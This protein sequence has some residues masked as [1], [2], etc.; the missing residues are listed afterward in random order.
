MVSRNRAWADARFI[1]TVLA[2]GTPIAANLL[3]DAP[4]LDTLTATRIIGDVTVLYDQAS[5]VVDSLSLVECGIGVTSVEAFAAGVGSLPTPD[6]STEYPPRGWLYC[7][8]QAVYQ[9][10]ESTGVLSTNARFVFDVGAMRKI[11][12]GVLF[13]VFTNTNLVIGGAM[14]IVG[15]IRTLCLT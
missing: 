3:V 1:G 13:V 11:D 5:T 9:Q 10:A 12:K 2:A 14:R 6:I 7:A 8:G 15:R 4:T